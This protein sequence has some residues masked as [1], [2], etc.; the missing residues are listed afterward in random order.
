MGIRIITFSPSGRKSRLI[1]P[2]SSRVMFISISLVPKPVYVGAPN[3]DRPVSL[4]LSVS[5]R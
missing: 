5:I 1:V 4:Q 2:C 3:S